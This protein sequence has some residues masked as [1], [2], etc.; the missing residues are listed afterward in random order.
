L[1]TMGLLQRH[2][3]SRMPCLSYNSPGLPR[4]RCNRRRPLIA[5]SLASNACP[6]MTCQE[7]LRHHCI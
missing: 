2:P 6:W 7:R 4:P 5:R 3:N 1:L